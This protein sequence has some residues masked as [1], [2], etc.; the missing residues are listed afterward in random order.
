MVIP[1]TTLVSVVPA[2]RTT[3][4]AVRFHP[5]FVTVPDHDGVLQVQSHRRNVVDEGVPVAFILAVVTV[6]ASIVHT[7]P[8]PLTVISHL[9]QSVTHPPEIV[10]ILS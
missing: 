8:L 2:P 6:E 10:S 1:V 7:V 9:S 4:L 5:V 3:A